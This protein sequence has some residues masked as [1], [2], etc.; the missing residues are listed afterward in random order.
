M[1]RWKYV[2]PRLGLLA[3]VVLFIN[4]MANPI[5]RLLLIHSAQAVT[6]A[7]VDIAK[8]D[9]SFWRGKIKVTNLQCADR[10]DP[11]KNLIQLESGEFSMDTGRALHKQW[12]V[13]DAKLNLL[14][15]GTPRTESGALAHSKSSGDS[16]GTSVVRVVREQASQ[17]GKQWLQQM[18]AHLPTLV[19]DNL[20]TVRLA[21]E[22]KVR[23]PA[24]FERHRARAMEL[25]KRAESIQ[26]MV[27][28]RTDNPLR[29]LEIYQNAI[30]ESQKIANEISAAQRELH[31]LTS[32]FQRDREA[33]IAAEQRDRNRLSSI[34]SDF[35]LNSRSVNELL[36][37]DEQARRVSE[38]VGWIN[39]F[40]DS[41]PDTE[42]FQP[43]RARGFDVTFSRQ[44]EF[45]FRNMEV[46]GEGIIGGKTIK[47]FGA[48]K[49]LSTAPRLM[50]E[51]VSIELRGQG[52]THV[53][54]I[55]TIDRRTT[56]S[57]DTI[58]INCP[59]I[60]VPGTTLGNAGSLL[61]AM[62]PSNLSLLIDA[63]VVDDQIKGQIQIRQKDVQM[64][65]QQAA[66]LA[67]GQLLVQSLNQQ[68]AAMDGF[69]VT[70]DLSGTV[71]APRMD[72]HSDLGQQ[73]ADMMGSAFREN[74]ASATINNTAELQ[75]ILDRQLSS[76]D[77]LFD[78]N[79][80]EL[81][82]LL[83]N[84]VTAIANLEAMMG[85]SGAVLPKFK[86]R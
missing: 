13:E 73:I 42:D 53:H 67:G 44:P 19:H 65:V 26:A 2:L 4:A 84:E 48:A 39:W 27:Q 43:Q 60:S 54:V 79:S 14:Q 72:L 23:W 10:R 16:V 24:E 18:E 12:V 36:L 33:L 76:L 80:N 66:S 9:A 30:M 29:D 40:R 77:Q 62:G 34:G 83:T 5:A 11:M 49:N 78:L 41:I 15:F 56:Q 25:K 55:A 22:L 50:S 7:R 35:S 82:G 1:I 52:D 59:L 45:V 8:V 37:G 21:R 74:I 6:G 63:T 68:I 28:K 85:T 75:G 47:F 61:V 46:G 51:P 17:L 70:V 3:I 31:Q 69:S 38:V 20:E 86:M 57:V 64:E 32:R 58:R 81:L 71:D